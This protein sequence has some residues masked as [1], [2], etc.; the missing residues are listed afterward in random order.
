MQ[1][2][3]EVM[4]HGRKPDARVLTIEPGG[5][6]RVGRLPNLNL[7]LDDETVSR[8]HAVVECVGEDGL[9]VVD[10]GSIHGTK[11]GGVPTS[12]A[13]LKSGDEVLFGAA[14]VRVTFPYVQ[15]V[16]VEYIPPETKR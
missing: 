6:I 2:K 4:G 15:M 7:W 14:W 5:A 8:L 11:V 16:D 10:L 9:R 12:T 1:V 3:F 13:N